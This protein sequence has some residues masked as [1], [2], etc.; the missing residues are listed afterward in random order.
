MCIVAAA[1]A[2]KQLSRLKDCLSG[3]SNT[4]WA[5]DNLPNRQCHFG[6]PPGYSRTD[7]CGDA[8]PPPAGPA[9]SARWHICIT[10]NTSFRNPPALKKH[11]SFFCERTDDWVCSI[12]QCQVFDSL[13][14][15]SQHHRS[16]HGDE[17]PNCC[18]LG[19]SP[20]SDHCKALLSQSSINAANKKAW[21]CPCCIMCFE[22]FK[23]WNKHTINHQVHN[24][25]VVNWSFSTMFRSLLCHRDLR[26][27]CRKYD[28]S[29]CN[30][31]YMGREECLA[32]R[33]ALERHVLPSDVF[34]N[35]TYSHLD[36]LE[37]L[38]LHAF[39]LGVV[40]NATAIPLNPTV[41]QTAMDTLPVYPNASTNQFSGIESM[42]LNS[43][44]QSVPERCNDFGSEEHQQRLPVI[45]AHAEGDVGQMDNVSLRYRK[46][47]GILRTWVSVNDEGFEGYQQGSQNLDAY[48]PIPG[49]QNGPQKLRQMKLPRQRT[50]TDHRTPIRRRPDAKQLGGALHDWVN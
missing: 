31:A 26:A 42:T 17:C 30:W 22:S 23:T 48:I 40:G 11:Q 21:G 15:L 25:R 45:L 2:L 27:A 8:L 6:A 1:S 32:L 3:S 12:C 47:N 16:V 37:S 24:E 20:A 9:A 35:E 43:R 18:S 28:W 39:C 50:R 10:C 41:P 33:S 29:R 7:L 4:N 19:K 36:M 49:S 14:K 46:A 13:T 38:V 44:Q 5:G 34:N